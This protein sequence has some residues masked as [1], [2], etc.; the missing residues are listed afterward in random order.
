MVVFN[1]TTECYSVIYYF[2]LFTTARVDPAKLICDKVMCNLI[3][4][5][6]IPLYHDITSILYV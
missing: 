6:V 2:E 5:S 3:P 4:L 1:R